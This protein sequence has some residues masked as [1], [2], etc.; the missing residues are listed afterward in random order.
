MT[1]PAVRRLNAAFALAAFDD[2]AAGVEP[3]EAT[4]TVDEVTDPTLPPRRP[5]ATAT[6]AV[7]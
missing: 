6:P 2:T 4:E 3:R 5:P 7:E 1:A